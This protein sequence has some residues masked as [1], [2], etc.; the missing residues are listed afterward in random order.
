MFSINKVCLAGALVSAIAAALMASGCNVAGASGLQRAS[1][2]RVATTLEA[3]SPRMVVAG[4]A[5]LLH[6]DVHGRQALR[7]YSVKRDAT[8]AVDCAAKVRADVVALHQGA[9][10]ELN[11]RVT[12]DEAICMADDSNGPGR[13]ARR[14][15]VSWH[16]RRGAEEPS[17][18]MHARND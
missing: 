9:S 12:E 10:N 13:D 14:T 16:A 18:V 8:G 3:G 2:V 11:L 17:E 1:E 6:V 7:I 4:P 5:R 15:D